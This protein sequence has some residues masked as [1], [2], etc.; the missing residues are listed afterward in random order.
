MYPAYSPSTV[1]YV[2]LWC[3]RLILSALTVTDR[4]T[5]IGE[6]SAQNR[7]LNDERFSA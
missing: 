7:L 5:Y 2:R 4:F 6:P 3:A 1:P